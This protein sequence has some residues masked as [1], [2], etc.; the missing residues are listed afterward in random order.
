METPYKYWTRKRFEEHFLE[1]SK[2]YPIDVNK[3]MMMI[4]DK[5]WNPIID[6]NGCNVVQD[7][8]HPFY[9]CFEHD[10]EW[11]VNGGGK[12]Y[13]V[14]FNKRL[15]E[16]DVAEYVAKLMY[17]GVRIG[18]CLWIKWKKKFNL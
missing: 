4:Y 12:K 7:K 10:Y 5:K 17:Y 1:Q 9:P 18:W 2:D 14:Q 16:F 6:Y 11:F 3:M 13:D 8:F 15:L